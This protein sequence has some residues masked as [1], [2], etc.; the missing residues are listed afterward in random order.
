MSR[1]RHRGVAQFV[2]APLEVSHLHLNCSSGLSLPTKLFTFF[3]HVG[4]AFE[5]KLESSGSVRP[6]T[7]IAFPTCGSDASIPRART[8]W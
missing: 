5:E 1:V 2:H 7:H 8:E 4:R 6:V 3:R